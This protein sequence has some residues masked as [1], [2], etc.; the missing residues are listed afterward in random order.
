MKTIAALVALGLAGGA[1][2]QQ[3]G[4]PPS[5]PPPYGKAIGER[6]VPSAGMAGLD[7]KR[8][9]SMKLGDQPPAYRIYA[10]YRTDRDGCPDPIVLQDGIGANRERQL[11]LTRVP[12]RLGEVR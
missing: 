1:A 3:A 5:P 9:P 7:K 12:P 6:C 10:L 11:P 8:P 4:T 2:A